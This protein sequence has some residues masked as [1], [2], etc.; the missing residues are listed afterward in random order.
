MNRNRSK[1]LLGLW[2][3]AVIGMSGSLALADN[4]GDAPTPYPTCAHT[5]HYDEYLGATVLSD[6]VNPVTPAW[7]GSTDDDGVRVEN[8][9]KGSNAVITVTV[10]NFAAADDIGVWIDWNDNG[11]WADAGEQVIWAGVSSAAPDGS[12]HGGDNI[13][14]VPVPVDAVGSSA[15]LRARIWYTT[16]PGDDEFDVNQGGSPD[17]VAKFGEVE[18]YDLPYA[19]PDDPE[20]KVLDGAAQDIPNGTVNEIITPLRPGDT[21]TLTWNI[22][23][24]GASNDLNLSTSPRV[25]LPA[26]SLLNCTVV[27]TTDAQ[28][29]VVPG[30]TTPFVIEVTPTA[31]G[32]FGFEVLIANDDPDE[33]AFAFTVSGS[34]PSALIGTYLVSNDMAENPH[35]AD[36]GEAFDALES[37]G[38][39]GAVVLE[40]SAGSGPYSSTSAYG[41]GDD[42]VVNVSA[43]NT[44]TIRAQGSERPVIH[45]SGAYE[46]SYRVLGTLLLKHIAHITIEGLELTGGDNFGI[47]VVDISAEVTSDINI[48]RCRIHDIQ[49]ANGI[50]FLSESP[51]TIANVEI[52]N[53]MI[54]DC[55][56]DQGEFYS[57]GEGGMGF[58]NL[59]P[60]A[61]IQHNTIVATNGIG[62]GHAVNI[63]GGGGPLAD[64]S[65]NIVVSATENFTAMNLAAAPTVAD[66]NIY[67]L[68]NGATEFA[69]GFA[70]LA[71]WQAANST[72]DQASSDLDPMLVS[73]IAGS[74]DLHLTLDSINAMDMAIGSSEI[75]DVDGDVRPDAADV[76]IGAD[77]IQQALSLRIHSGQTLVRE[78]DVL[79]VALGAAVADLSLSFSVLDPDVGDTLGLVATVTD[80]S[81]VDGFVQAEWD[82]TGTGGS[83]AATPTSGTFTTA[84]NI[85]VQLDADDGAGGHTVS[86]TFTIQVKNAPAI[87]VLANAVAVVDGD[88]L[89]VS[90]GDTLAGLN[91]AFAVDDADV[92]DTLSLTTTVTDA[93]AIAAFVQDEWNSTGTGGNI[94]AVPTT[95]SFD[96]LGAITVQLDAGDGTGLTDTLS[97]TIVVTGAPAITVTAFGNAVSDG[98]TLAMTIGDALAALSLDL[99]VTDPDVGDTLTLAATVTNSELITG[100]DAAEWD[101][102]GTGGTIGATPT[103]GTLDT[104]GS[105]TVQLD[106]DDGTGKTDTLIFTITVSEPGN[107]APVVS[108]TAGGAAVSN[109]D[110][111]AMTIGDTVADLDLAISV[112]DADVANTLTLVSV[113]TDNTLID[114]FAQGEWDGTGSGGSI[115][116]A[117]SS[118]SFDTLGTI[119]VQLNASD[120]VGGADSFSFILTVSEPANHP[121]VL[122]VTRNASAVNEGDNLAVANGATVASLGLVFTI[123]DADAGDTLTLTS[124]VTDNSLIAGFLQ[125]E[126]DATGSG[127]SVVANPGTGS[128]T[129]DGTLSVSL[130]VTDG[131]GGTDTFAFLITVSTHVNQAPVISV[132][133]NGVPLMSGSTVESLQGGAVSSLNLNFGV[134]DV[135]AGDNLSLTATLSDN[136]L[137]PGF[138]PAEWTATGSGGAITTSP[139]TGTFTTGGMIAVQLT[140][141]DGAGGTANLNFNISVKTGGNIAPVISAPQPTG[142]I[143]GGGTDPSFVGSVLVGGNLAIAFAATDADA[144]DT[145][146][147]SVAVAGGTLTAAQ[148]GFVEVLPYAPVGG[149]SPQVLTLSGQA[150]TEG[151]ITLAVT[152]SDD[153][154]NSDQ[155]SFT[156]AIKTLSAGDSGCG[157]AHSTGHNQ[158]PGGLLLALFLGMAINRQRRRR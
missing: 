157:C 105:I 77:E 85:T 81:A 136:S 36:L 8:L 18:D 67:F 93:G 39:A 75:I 80:N 29:P 147:F 158:L 98:D 56:I 126:W 41:L 146:S 70:T 78:G 90:Q 117:P 68:T 20:I 125:T 150:L 113:V 139:S 40:V 127:G 54:W 154:G 99:A 92:G 134:T 50:W 119:T 135:D 89:T 57:T 118:G 87:S 84:G 28:T 129:T 52:V 45:G 31:A 10:S 108:V 15:K 82:T 42:S 6:S 121:P 142:D 65:Y 38:V 34:S 25:D 16:N 155:Y 22:E 144:A 100:F 86:L 149:T 141:T 46:D 124:T 104:L 51:H 66:H 132:T 72:L 2:I 143:V 35:F 94:Q 21:E 49:L 60:N 111:L 153:S 59:G 102:T 43:V 74:E 24:I 48:R 109:G 12:I 114:G 123:S 9:S 101:A 64:F 140:A 79:P 156:L 83:I 107:N 115:A 47:G 96:T 137:I 5:F 88:T 133:S 32:A 17:G 61:V 151:T 44:I 3:T 116:A 19:L 23:N 69:P 4:Y 27:L 76:D 63:E 120:G 91:L 148:A 33:S 37:H 55:A 138:V 73:V 11:D 106:A 131:A 103:T 122:T 128:F 53:N 112:T 13:C 7:T 62:S 14:L 145:L 58:F 152:V 71:D 130:S 97:F 30:A 110:T 95:G 26:G 1:T